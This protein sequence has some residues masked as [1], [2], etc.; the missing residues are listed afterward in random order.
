MTP[1]EVN[2]AIEWFDKRNT[3]MPGAR[4]MYRLAWS[5][6][7]A[8]KVDQVRLEGLDREGLIA[9]IH[10]LR[11]ANINRGHLIDQLEDE[12][13]RLKGGKE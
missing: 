2:E 8:L 6:L 9:V 5:A 4:K 13:Y 1:E 10:Y 7:K 11:A 12:N 3:P